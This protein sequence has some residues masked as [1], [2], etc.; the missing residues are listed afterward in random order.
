MMK[1]YYFL[2]LLS[3]TGCGHSQTDRAPLVVHPG[4][5]IPGIVAKGMT[6]AEMK[7][8][9]GDTKIYSNSVNVIFPSI[10]V[11]FDLGNRTVPNCNEPCNGAIV[12][13]VSHP[14][15]PNLH[16]SGSVSG[17]H[18]LAAVP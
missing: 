16:F 11:R 8:A 10:G 14:D 3:L 18:R 9:T 7:K 6:L 12:F 4:I 13:L 17:G 1:R 5:G 2:I 15:Y